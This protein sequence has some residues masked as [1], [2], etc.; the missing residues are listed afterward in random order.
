VHADKGDF[1][2]AASE[3]AGQLYGYG[4]G[5]VL[6]KPTKSTNHP[7]RPTGYGQG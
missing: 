5:N 1:V 3:A 2:A 7:F 6:F 4:H